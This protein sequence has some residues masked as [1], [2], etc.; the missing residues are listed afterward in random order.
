MR[1]CFFLNV[2]IILAYSV[3]LFA[4]DKNQMKFEFSDIDYGFSTRSILND[5][6]VS[7]VDTGKGENT[8]VLI[9][10]LGSNAGFWRYNIPE[11][12]KSNRVIAIDLPGYGKSS[13]GDYKY[14]ISFFS[15][16]L[17]FFF[18]KLKIKNF[19]LAGHSMGGQICI[20]FALKYPEYVKKLILIS[21]AGV[22]P[23][24]E[25]QSN[26]LKNVFTP[27]TIKMSNRETIVKNIKSNFFVWDEKYNWLIE[28]RIKIIAADDFDLYAKA[29]AK[30]VAGMLDEPTTG[31]LK[32]ISVPVL[33]IYGEKDNLIPNKYF[34]PG[35][36]TDSLFKTGAAEIR[37]CTLAS[38][39]DAG[40][41]VYIEKSAEVDKIILNYIDE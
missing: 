28:E 19:Y 11:L 4:Q 9:H 29:A 13:K 37:N 32:N 5:P 27:E 7:Y 21:P 24:N 8:I 40:H 23:F 12:S 34:H 17:K 41:L 1:K 16:T 15:E 36:T 14:N 26:F 38:V 22:E 39:K 31:F 30:S 6:A 18:D 2:V 3:L 20:E 33:I 25:V 35:V 10:G